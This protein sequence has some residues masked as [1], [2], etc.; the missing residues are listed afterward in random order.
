[1]F[2]PDLGYRHS[3]DLGA[4]E[5]INSQMMKQKLR[6]FYAPNVHAFRLYATAG[7]PGAEEESNVCP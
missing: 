2:N 5:G 4:N 6:E 1:M 3:C 7:E